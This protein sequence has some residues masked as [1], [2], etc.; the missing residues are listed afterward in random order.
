ME[1]FVR[2]P[3]THPF[4]INTSSALRASAS[5]QDNGQ[6]RP[7]TETSGRLIRRRFRG[8]A[9]GLPK[10]LRRVAV[11]GADVELL[12]WYASRDEPENCDSFGANISGEK[13][14]IPE[15]NDDGYLPPGIQIGRAS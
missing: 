10:L 3:G 2:S 9:H 6:V 4:S 5:P 15:F 1:S 11:L 8:H 14:M 13:V 7:G 12:F